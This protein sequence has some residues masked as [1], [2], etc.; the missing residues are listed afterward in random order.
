LKPRPSRWSYG[1]LSFLLKIYLI[2]GTV[3]LMAGVIWYN[4]N[5]IS[6]MR[7]QS[8]STTRLF[9][10]FIAI[11]LRDVNDQTRQQFIRD[12]R[13]AITLPFVLTDRA[14][15]PVV[16]NGIGVPM[17]SDD[18][19]HRILDY[20]PSDPDDEVLE[21]VQR[22]AGEFDRINEPVSVE[23]EEMVLEIHY[24][25]SRLS[26]E[27]QFAPFI[28]IGVLL[29]F[30]IFGFLMF[31]SLK[32]GEQ[33]SIWVGM[34]KETAHQLGT[35]LSSMMG[36]LAIIRERAEEAGCTAELT[37]PIEEASDDVERLSRISSRFSKIGSI[38]DLE[39][40]D[41][42]PLIRETVEYFER[43]RPA[44]KIESIIEVEIE[45][46]PVIRCSADLLRWVFENLIKNSLDAIPDEGGKI[47]IKVG[48][49]RENESIEVLFSD[50]GKGM[51]SSL[52][53]RVFTPGVTTKSRGWGLGLAL[54]R[55][56]VEEIHGGTIRILHSQPGRGTTFR[57]TFP[58]D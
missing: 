20:D 58:V 27:L 10:R 6:R 35:P 1:N 15:R 4:N 47:R 54:V 44:L 32:T 43:R 50:N 37:G 41:I 7:A 14:G 39:Y 3:I 19:Y 46:L 12:V 11:A 24:G 52:R 57:I 53:K 2:A 5:L 21:K 45:E 25:Y 18:E 22:A 36:W 56:I 28:Q 31:R 23:T 9:S 49:D 29:L 38:P 13:G 16:W 33:R 42:S 34:A 55:R 48:L 26:R 17:L 30:M 8:E 40:R 51:S